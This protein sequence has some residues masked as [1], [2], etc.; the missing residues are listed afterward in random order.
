MSISFSRKI[1]L[2]I[3]V[4]S[5]SS[6]TLS[7]AAREAPSGENDPFSSVLRWLGEWAAQRVSPRSDVPDEPDVGVRDKSA[8]PEK[9]HLQGPCT[10]L[11]DANAAADPSGSTCP[12]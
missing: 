8:S 4:L 9:P 12:D 7:V 1:I 5:L 10:P 11:G 3:V 6:P 2:A